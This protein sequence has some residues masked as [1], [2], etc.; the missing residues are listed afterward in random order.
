MFLKLHF[1]IELPKKLSNWTNADAGKIK[2][3]TALHKFSLN[4]SE[5]ILNQIH[6][7]DHLKLPIKQHP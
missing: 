7:K 4:A 1:P 2:I 5:S 3:F 6:R